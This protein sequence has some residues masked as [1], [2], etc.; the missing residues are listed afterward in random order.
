ERD[1]QEASYH[2]RIT[3]PVAATASADFITV[4]VSNFGNLAV[5]TLGNPMSY[6]EE[7]TD[8][9][10]DPD[11]HSRITGSLSGLDYITVPEH[12][13]WAD[14]DGVLDLRS[15]ARSWFDRFFFWT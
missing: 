5:V 10:L 14:Y 4:T 1:V 13:T 2:G 3:I 9:L 11:D 6:D 7:E 8:Y 12:L 15:H